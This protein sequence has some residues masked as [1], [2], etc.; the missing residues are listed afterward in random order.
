MFAAKETEAT[1]AADKPTITLADLTKLQDQQNKAAP[2]TP[3]EIDDFATAALVI[4]RGLPLSDKKKVIGRM[5]R[6]AR[7][8]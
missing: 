5:T 6:L 7:R 3:D 4:L 2:L 1:V 8:W